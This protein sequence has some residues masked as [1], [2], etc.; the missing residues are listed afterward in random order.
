[1]LQEAGTFITVYISVITFMLGAS[2]GSFLTCVSDRLALHETVVRSNSH[3]PSCGHRLGV[4]DLVPVFSWIFLKGRCRY[5]KGKIPVSCLITELVM[6]TAFLT[7]LLYFDIS[8]DLLTGLVLVCICFT[9]SMTDIITGEIPNILSVLFCIIWATTIPL[10]IKGIWSYLI[11]SAIG[12]LGMP[13]FLMIMAIVMENF[14]G[15]EA[16]GGGDIKILCPAGLILGWKNMLV[17]L[18]VM[19]ITGLMFAGIRAL[20]RLRKEQKEQKEKDK[21]ENRITDADTAPEDGSTIK[22]MPFISLGVFT[23][24]VFGEA[25]TGLYMGL[26]GI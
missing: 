13:L 20:L 12:G 18:L 22:L 4:P 16:L 10:H 1:M 21:N 6:G 15:R 7:M 2:F 17:A 14:L 5:C 26:F 9:G 23:A 25:L 8:W 3:C 11:D 19:C 24:F